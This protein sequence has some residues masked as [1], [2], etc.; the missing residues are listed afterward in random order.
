M[1]V[2]KKKKRS[3]WLS[4]VDLLTYDFTVK[5]GEKKHSKKTKMKPSVW[6]NENKESL[7]SWEPGFKK[8]IVLFFSFYAL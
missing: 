3:Q 6:Q 4:L 1:S 7:M 8:K 2:V 5:S